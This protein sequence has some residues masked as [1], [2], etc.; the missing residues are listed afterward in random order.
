[1]NRVFPQ[2]MHEHTSIY[3][4]SKRDH[5]SRSMQNSVIMGIHACNDGQNLL[6]NA[7]GPGCLGFF[8]GLYYPVLWGFI[9]T[10]S[11]HLWLDHCPMNRFTLVS[12]VPSHPDG[13]MVQLLEFFIL[14]FGNCNQ[15]LMQMTTEE[16]KQKTWLFR[17]YGGFYYPVLKGIIQNPYI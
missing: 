14:Q 8:G 6:S 13:L 7:K 4:H 17:V 2:I 11:C 5:I 10:L 1:M 3:Q 16:W 15:W 9:F 12:H